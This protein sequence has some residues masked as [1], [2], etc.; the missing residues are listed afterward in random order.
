MQMHDID[1]KRV[2]VVQVTR[3]MPTRRNVS[4]VNALLRRGAAF[5]QKANI[6]CV[7]T[8]RNVALTEALERT[9]EILLLVDDDIIFGLDQASELIAATLSTGVAHSGRY[10]QTDGRLA[11]TRIARDRWYTGLGFVAIVRQALLDVAPRKVRLINDS[12]IYPIC[13]AG[14]VDDNWITDDYSLCQRIGGVILANIDVAH[15]KPFELLPKPR[16]STDDD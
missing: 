3:D 13:T 11:A 4:A 7:C 9:E 1:F 5:V 6:S 16:T 15:R 8:A 10:I 2:C 12:F 14:V